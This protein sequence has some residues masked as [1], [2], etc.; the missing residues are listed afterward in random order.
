MRV[1]FRRIILGIFLLPGLPLLWV[2]LVKEIRSYSD[3]SGQHTNL[4]ESKTKSTTKAVL[5]RGLSS[6]I[7]HNDQPDKKGGHLKGS[8]PKSD[9]TASDDE[10]FSERIFDIAAM[11]EVSIPPDILRIMN[12][13]TPKSTTIPRSKAVLPPPKDDCPHLKKI[14]AKDQ[15]WQPVTKD[16]SAYVF[17]AFLDDLS[18]QIVRIIGMR[19]R[20][21]APDLF[22][23]I[24]FDNKTN[25][26]NSNNNTRT[27]QHIPRFVVVA[28]T[29]RLIPEDHGR[30]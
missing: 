25:I 24:W 8:I 1:S 20:S 18:G 13:S 28:A 29:L 4:L 16:R 22:C 30:K 21:L 23:Q 3:I 2:H 15:E 5:G 14:I 10:E 6:S 27:E 7:D 11:K 12:L 26:N 17:S 9:S 19:S